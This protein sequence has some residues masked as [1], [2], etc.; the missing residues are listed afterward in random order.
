[1]IRQAWSLRNIVELDIG[2]DLKALEVFV[3]IVE[4]GGMTAAGQRLGLTQSSVSQSLAHLEQSLRVQLLDRSQRPS[5]LTPMGRH[6]YERA[7][8]LLNSA[9][10]ISQEFRRKDTVLL[11]QVRIALVDSLVTSVGK[12]LVDAVKQRT[13]QWSLLT[14]QSHRHAAALLAH[15]VDIL[16]SDDP[17]ANHPELYRRALIREPFVLVLPREF[18]EPKSSLRVLAAS[19]DFIRYNNGTVIGRTIEHQLQHWGINPPLRLQLDNSSAIVSAVRAGL[20][21]S[22]TTPLCMLESGL[23]SGNV[24]ILPVPGGEFFRELTLIAHQNELGQ[25][26]RQLA[27]D[28]IAVLKS[29]YIPLIEQHAPWL[30]SSIG[31]GDVR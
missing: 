10:H 4:A 19:A 21:W 23:T 12:E 31:L 22:I 3:A 14:G 9:R 17:V 28:T 5:V 18:S 26:P 29:R 6:F 24:Q 13:A 16:M 11:K 15:K 20:G 30:L 7:S 2:F 25:L 8:Q 27:D 1:M